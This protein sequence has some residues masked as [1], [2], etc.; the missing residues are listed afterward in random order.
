MEIVIAVG[1][2]TVWQPNRYILSFRHAFIYL[3]LSSGNYLLLN[4]SPVIGLITNGGLVLVSKPF[5]GS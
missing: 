4:H 5:K 3:D 2:R 1:R